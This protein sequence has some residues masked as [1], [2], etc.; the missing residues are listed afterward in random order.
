M[1]R[2]QQIVP[3][4]ASGQQQ[5]RPARKRLAPTLVTGS[6]T[7]TAQAPVAVATAAT[8]PSFSVCSNDAITLRFVSKVEDVVEDVAASAAAPE[9]FHPT[10]THQIF[11]DAQRI[12]GYNGLH[13]E[14]LLT[15]G[16]MR[17]FVRSTWQERRADGACDINP[18]VT[19]SRKLPDAHPCAS[20]EEFRAAVAAENAPGQTAFTPPG[21]LVCMHHKF[22]R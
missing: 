5:N 9:S 15:S 7:T 1:D 19:L 14:I 11:G 3:R 20:L 4:S 13:A 6:T 12:L 8:V 10:Y 18:A 17:A 2:P 21:K 22:T 16:S